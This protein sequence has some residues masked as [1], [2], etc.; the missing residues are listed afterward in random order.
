LI[1]NAETGMFDAAP[2]IMTTL[3]DNYPSYI[4]TAAGEVKARGAELIIISDKAE[5]A[6]HLDPNPIII[7]SNGP[8][9]ALGAVLPLQL[10]GSEHQHHH[11]S[12][13]FYAV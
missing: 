13:W 12:K 4:Q 6:H 7:P 5:W 1:E 11:P 10:I 2:I 9:T 8:R 3:D